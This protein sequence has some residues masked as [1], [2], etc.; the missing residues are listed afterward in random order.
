MNLLSA[1]SL[2]N[3]INKDLYFV[4]YFFL[5]MLYPKMRQY[6]NFLCFYVEKIY[7]HTSLVSPTVSRFM[8]FNEPF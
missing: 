6:K 3:G 2:K 5:L 7:I 8:F 1:K 4:R